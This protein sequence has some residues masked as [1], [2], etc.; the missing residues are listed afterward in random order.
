MRQSRRNR[1]RQSSQRRE[2]RLAFLVVLA[3]A[4]FIALTPG[5]SAPDSLFGR[6]KF[7]HLA[8]FAALAVLARAGWPRRTR[9]LTGGLLFVYGMGIELVQSIPLVGRTASIAD[10]AANGLGIAAG[11]LLAWAGGRFPRGPG[12]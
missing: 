9:L 4:S 10:L 8:A 6:D 11:L 7:D 2:I 3:I 5:P 12:R 1:N